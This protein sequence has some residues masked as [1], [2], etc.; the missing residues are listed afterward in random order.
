[1]MTSMT[2]RTRSGKVPIGCT[3]TMVLMIWLLAS[4]PVH[5]QVVG[6]TLSGTITDESRGAIPKATVSVVNVATGV[7]T[8]VTTNAVGIFVVPNLLPGNYEATISAD[9]FQKAI[10]N[11]IVLT[12]GAQQVLNVTMKVGSV[13]QSVEVSTQAPDVQLASSTINGV[14]SSN[15][16]VELPLNGRSWTD[17]ATLEPGVSSIRD[18]VSTTKSD[19]LGRGLGNEISITGG[20]P[21]QNNYLVNGVSI[22][23]YSGQA[24]G[25]FLGQNL[26][27]DAVE[28]FTVLTTNFSTEYGRSSGGVISAITR[29]GTNTFHGSAYEFLRNNA[30]DARNFFDGPT[31]PPFRRNQFGVS[32][33]GPIRKDKTFIFADFEGLRQT[34]G[35]S[36]P[37]QVPSRAARGIAPGGT[38]PSQQAV[39]SGM[40]LPLVKG[41]PGAAVNPDPVTGVDTKVEPFLA[42]FYPLPNAGESGDVGTFLF[43]GSQI[44]SDN[45]FTTRV[46]H[47]FSASDSVAGTYLYDNSNSSQPDELDNK[48]IAS[49]V[50]R[51]TVTGEEN[52]VFSA[53]LV[54][55]F[56]L[57]YNHILASSPSAVSAINPKV[58][59][60]SGTYSFVP[61]YTVGGIIN[62]SG[63]TDFTG[64]LSEFKPS[65]T[66]WNDYQAY[67]NVFLTKGIHSLKFGANVERIHDHNTAAC[68]MCAGNFQIDTLQK[69]LTN[70]PKAI[71][72]TPI[73]PLS[74]TRSEWIVGAYIQ[75]DIRF[76]P[77]LMIN[78]GLR[79]EMA[80]VPY[81]SNG[82]E[83]SLHTLDGTEMFAVSLAALGPAPLAPCTG[84]AIVGCLPAQ[85]SPVASPLFKNPSTR[86]FEPRV[87]FSWDP[88]KNGKTAI[89]GGFG[90]FDVQILPPNLRS[91]IGAYPFTQ[92]FNSSKLPPGSFPTPMIPPSGPKAATSQR[93]T[94][95]EQNPK[96]NYVMQ[97]NV[98][99]QRQITP[100]T[101]VMIAFVGSRTVHNLLVTD[102]SAI[103]LPMAKTPQGYL[104]PCGPDGSG[105]PC[106]V[107]FSPSGTRANPIT[108]TF[109][110]TSCPGQPGQAVPAGCWGRVSSQFWGS[111]ARFHALEA[112]ISK[113]MSHGLRA[114]ASY[115]YGRSVDTSS[116]STDGDQFLNG[117]SSLPFFDPSV[118]RGPSDF[119]VPHNLEVN[120]NW[121]I[122]SPKGVSGFLGWASSGWE[123]GGIFEASSGTPFTPIIVGGL[124]NAADPLGM[125][126]TDTLDYPEL[127]RGCN[128][129]HG[130]V[131]YLNLNCF[132]L[133]KSTPAIAA[134]C[135]PFGLGVNGP[136]GPNGPMG[137]A[138]TCENLIGNAGRNSVV[139]PKIINL[140]MSM[141]KDTHIKRISETFNA[142]FRVEVFNILNHANFLSPVAPVANNAMFDQDGNPVPLAGQI[143]STATNSRQLQLAL[144]LTW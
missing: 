47:R 8:T 84:T 111:D 15:T 103:V 40:P 80:T 81:A 134:Q 88:F 16:I 75:D 97:W 31:V 130:G 114:K 25:S 86:D 28:E 32:G 74:L 6:A 24:P 3:H 52:H 139:G 126:S 55:T 21:Q 98:N 20:R 37:Q 96:R 76:R 54:N 30:F 131:N 61:G 112:Q 45:Y 140:D 43:A 142:Q 58:A 14:V 135:Q 39:V 44:S 57:G 26:G 77:N 128:P 35:T 56:R 121:Q 105:N 9:G 78:A 29:S 49:T 1:M 83:G 23:D 62:I 10:Q 36:V 109:L 2:T 133:P 101:T 102:D 22:N 115:T 124:A 118:R 87:G 12:V 71:I 107:G 100:N 132:T 63:L 41:Q 99:L 38:T 5:A 59:D 48:L 138:G 79:W 65:V 67:D 144:K 60:T 94:Y 91:G 106:V 68:V 127:V 141:F 123:F 7:S 90:M 143:S 19:R 85:T 119:N 125:N 42:A 70:Q 92:S 50:K 13:T 27:A 33:G 72:A 64:G 73:P 104:W 66:I 120:F 34:L 18:M 108:T 4:I 137:I 53:T 17:L 11:G 122:P 113:R 129:A 136:M 116:G 110:D 93:A 89:R 82:Q 117:L 69:F 95:I 46:D 51:Q